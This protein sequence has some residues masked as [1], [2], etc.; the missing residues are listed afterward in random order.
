MWQARIMDDTKKVK[1]HNGR[2]KGDNAPDYEPMTEDLEAWS[3]DAGCETA[4]IHAAW[5]EHDGHCPECGAGSWLLAL[6][7]I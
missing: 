2:G 5:V 6:G 3:W 4:C 7:L 1:R